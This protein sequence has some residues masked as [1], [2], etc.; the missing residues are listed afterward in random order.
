M[1]ES[2]PRSNVPSLLDF[3]HLMAE[4][5]VLF[6]RGILAF[7]LASAGKK[8]DDFRL[9]N[10]SFKMSKCPLFARLVKDES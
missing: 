1:F 5:N 4:Q 8:K 10:A 2:D 9:N 6:N 7:C 3:L